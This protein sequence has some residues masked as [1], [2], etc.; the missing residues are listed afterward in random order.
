M[1][2]AKRRPSAAPPAS[3]SGRRASDAPSFLTPASTVLL[4]EEVVDRIREAIL[5]REF[6]PGDR[7]REE[8]L[9]KS[10]RV[11]R[12]PVRNAL[13][14]LE[15]EGMVIRRRNRGAL[16]AHLSRADLEEVYSLRHAVEPVACVWA[17]RNAVEADFV[18]LQTIIDGYA[19]LTSK[20]TV[21][22][23]AEA[24]LTFH[25]ALYAAA[26]HRRLL[27]LWQDLRP[28]VY[29]FLLARKYVHTKEFRDVMVV[30]HTR[31]LDVIR[32][33]DEAAATAVAAA[34]VQTSYARVLDSYADERDIDG[35]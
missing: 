11:S 22:D 4:S 2:V 7:L 3:V 12:G 31:I 28:Q 6:E 9:A 13:L 24:D 16:V 30:N 33:R 26:R 5:M 19:R 10:L 29:L 34:H 1:P 17:A 32:A 25:D 15:R 23:A 21:Q 35:D 14:Q 20:V 18:E 27:S 8:Q